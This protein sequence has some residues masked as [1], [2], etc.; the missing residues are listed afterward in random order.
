MNERAIFLAALDIAGSAEREAYVNRVCGGDPALRRRIH[1]LLATYERTDTFLEVPAL[2]QIEDAIL[3]SWSR[4]LDFS[5]LQPPSKPGSLGKLRHY[6]IQEVIGRGGCGI[7]MKAFDETL[8]RV[9]AIKVMVPELAATSSARELFLR[10]A[11]A[12]AAINHDNVVSIHAV[13]DQPI[14]FLVMEYISG[15]TLQQKLK[16]GP[17]EVQEVVRIGCQIASGLEAAHAIGL[18]HRDIKPANIML[19]NERVKLTDFGLA[20]ATDDASLTQSGEIR[21]TPLYMSPEQAQGDTIDKRSDL[22]S[23]GSVLYEM[24]AGQ[25]PFRA[26]TILGVLRCVVEDQPR[27]IREIIS[28]VPGW[29]CVLIAK[30]HAKNSD[31]RFAS[32][33]ETANALL[34]SAKYGISAEDYSSLQEI[35]LK[36]KEIARKQFE[37]GAGLLGLHVDLNAPVE[38][39]AAGLKDLYCFS[40]N[41]KHWSEDAITEDFVGAATRFRRFGDALRTR[42]EADGALT[43]YEIA[44]RLL[45]AAGSIQDAECERGKLLSSLAEYHLRLGKTD[46][47]LREAQRNALESIDI[48][49]QQANAFELFQSYRILADVLLARGESKEAEK[50][51]DVAQAFWERCSAKTDETKRRLLGWLKRS[52]GDCNAAQGRWICARQEYDSALDIFKRGEDLIGMAI[53]KEKLADMDGKLGKS[54]KAAAELAEAVQIIKVVPG[55]EHLLDRIQHSFKLGRIGVASSISLTNATFDPLAALGYAAQNHFSPVQIYLDD[56]VVKDRRARKNVLARVQKYDLP[57]MLHA[58]GL[59]KLPEATDAEIVA[60]ALELLVCESSR[61]V[62]YHFDET[63]SVEES[64]AIVE[65]L[66]ALG[67]VPCI[68]KFHQLRG[69]DRARQNYANYLDLLSRIRDRSIEVVSVVDVPRTFHEALESTIE[70]ACALTIDLLRRIGSMEYSILFHLIDAKSAAQSRS[71]WCPLGKGIIPYS[72]IFREVAG[73]IRCDDVVLEF[74]DYESPLPSRE[75]LSRLPYCNW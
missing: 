67:I 71:D 59:L 13:E 17:L 39:M 29:L 53:V 38:E 7:V 18:I 48:H 40:L 2:Q 5:F 57:I 41:D 10:E 64:L 21:G 28:E 1:S 52:R 32:A 56:Q 19:E 75:F 42:G 37:V 66:C 73:E 4:K 45:N 14:P 50:Y 12:A 74:E 44:Q 65:S 58:P 23:L 51:L 36:Q 9:V 47:A 24:C 34:E 70:D 43:V 61:R 6:E 8:R 60:A 54:S 3:E 35:V 68:E 62:V 55:A 69:V 31:A 22:F 16:T 27:P 33:H 72:R 20:R 26:P 46:D 15:Q 25:P 49:K 11:R 63:Q 30:L